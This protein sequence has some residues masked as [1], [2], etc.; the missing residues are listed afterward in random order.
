VNT[1]AVPV[2]GRDPMLA[3]FSLVLVPKGKSASGAMAYDAALSVT[4][5]HYYDDMTNWLI[6]F[7][8]ADIATRM[9]EITGTMAG[10]YTNRFDHRLGVLEQ[11]IGLSLAF[12]DGAKF[13][14]EVAA[15]GSSA[16]VSDF[17]SSMDD[18]LSGSFSE[19]SRDAFR[20]YMD[21]VVELVFPARRNDVGAKWSEDAVSYT[22]QAGPASA[23]IP[24]AKL[25]RVVGRH[26]GRKPVPFSL[27][28]T[29]FSASGD[30]QYDTGLNMAV[31]IHGGKFSDV[32]D[33]DAATGIVETRTVTSEHEYRGA[34][35]AVTANLK[36]LCT[37]RADLVRISNA[38]SP[39]TETPDS[40]AK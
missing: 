21:Q 4:K 16:G 26:E 29:Y 17:K 3:D 13:T 39:S 40:S 28:S 22:V 6:D 36:S 15:D 27:A 34:T 5:V 10:L 2:R 8:C 32:W 37:W 30:S 18:R 20:E 23:V 14:I 25:T 11:N 38:A 33:V 7:P 9:S 24:N 12:L 1:P 35:S 19:R 31:S